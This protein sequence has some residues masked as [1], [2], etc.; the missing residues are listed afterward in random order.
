MA[1][2]EE[3]PSQIYIYNLFRGSCHVATPADLKGDP[4]RRVRIGDS[5]WSTVCNRKLTMPP[6]C[7]EISETP[8]R[9]FKPC[10]IKACRE[11]FDQI[12]GQGK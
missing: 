7:Y 10:G 5:V 12:Q 4:C 1:G 3:M 8:P 6:E 11:Q 2:E 9:Y